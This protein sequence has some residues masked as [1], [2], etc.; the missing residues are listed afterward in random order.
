MQKKINYQ[1]GIAYAIGNKALLSL[2]LNQ[3][4]E[5]ELL[6]LEALE[7][8]KQIGRRELIA[9]DYYYIA[10]ALAKQN[11]NLAEALTIV[12]RAI[13]IFSHLRMSK[14]LQ[15]AQQILAEIEKAISGE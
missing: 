10:K 4:E 7:L 13:E 8:A 3:W 5:C 12:H 1:E 15:D 9:Y 14:D 2:E 11:K 6:A